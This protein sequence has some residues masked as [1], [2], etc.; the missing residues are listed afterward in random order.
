MKKPEG[1]CRT[2]NMPLH[3]N[4]RGKHVK[5]L[6]VQKIWCNTEIVAAICCNLGQKHRSGSLIFELDLFFPD[7]HLDTKYEGSKSTPLTK[8]A[9][10]NSFNYNML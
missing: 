3:R 8:I 4:A 6:T 9:H 5:I 10:Q 2:S 1:K 7:V